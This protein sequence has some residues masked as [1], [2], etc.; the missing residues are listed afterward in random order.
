MSESTGLRVH[1]PE[2]TLSHRNADCSPG[3]EGDIYVYYSPKQINVCLVL[4]PPANAAE[5]K[6]QLTTIG[7]VQ[8]T[9]EYDTKGMTNLQLS[10]I[11][12]DATVIDIDEGKA[13]YA[14]KITQF[15]MA[16]AQPTNSES[17]L[18]ALQHSDLQPTSRASSYGSKT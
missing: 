8:C 18:K 13:W 5:L 14:P 16:I 10:P 6:P 3:V 9:T 15:T 2:R 1:F 17:I 7:R 11:S 4:K 12:V